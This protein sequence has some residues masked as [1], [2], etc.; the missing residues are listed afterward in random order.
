VVR[1]NG[2]GNTRKTIRAEPLIAEDSKTETFVALKLW[3]DS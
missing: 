2:I 1:E 3:I